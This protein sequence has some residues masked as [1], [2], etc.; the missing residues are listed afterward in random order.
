MFRSLLFSAAT[1]ALAAQN[2][3]SEGAKAPEPAVIEAVPAAPATASPALPAP[4]GGK[5]LATIGKTVIREPEF[6]LFLAIS[7]NEQERMT[8]QF[9][10]GSREQYLTRFLEFKALEAKARKAGF[11]KKEAHAKKLRMMD[12]Q[13]L[14]TD[15]MDRD[16]PGLQAQIKVSDAD[17]KAYFDK[18]PE[19]FRTPESFTARHILVATKAM[20]TE[21]VATE[22]EAKD[23]IA[24]IKTELAAGKTFEAAAKEYSADPG[25]KDKG[26]L[27]ENTPFGSFVPEFETAVRAQTIGKVGEP[28][29]SQYGYHLILVEKITPAVQETFEAAKEA[30]TKLATTERQEQ[31]M[32]AYM[33]AAK[34][35]V[36][37]VPAGDVKAAASVKT[38]STK[39]GK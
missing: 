10:P 17:V 14:I 34:K 3:T 25:S 30:A 26:G 16:G 38:A 23:T 5:V 1:L 31:V 6:E 12:M 7:L 21:K 11:Q 28:V 24:K 22:D 35:E 15:L 36:G 13:L 32:H 37:F 8:M 29:K 27:Y 20:G 39:V 18:H 4:K 2:P 33:D 9:M 19:K